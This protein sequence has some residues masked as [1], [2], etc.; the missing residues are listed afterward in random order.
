MT[1]QREGGY[2]FVSTATSVCGVDSTTGLVLWQGTTPERAR[3]VSRL[4]SSAYVVALNLPGDLREGANTAYFF[5]YRNASGVIS[6]NGGALDL[7]RVGDVRASLAADGA[8]IIQSGTTIRG[9][10]RE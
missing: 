9:F 8:I 10:A 5:D 4:L 3:F 6:R 2:L 7:G 1:V